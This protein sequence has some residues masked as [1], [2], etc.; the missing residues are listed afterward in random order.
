MGH[1]AGNDADTI[2]LIRLHIGTVDRFEG[3]EFFADARQ[4]FI[5]L[6]VKYQPKPGCGRQRAGF[7]SKGC[8]V[9]A[10]YEPLPG[11]VLPAVTDPDGGSEDNRNLKRF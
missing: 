5:E 8:P 10:G 7:F 6:P 1:A 4:F 2:R 11:Q 9:A 3:F